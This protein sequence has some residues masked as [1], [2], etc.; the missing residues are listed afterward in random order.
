[1]STKN[2]RSGGKYTGAHTTVIPAA[3]TVCDIAHKLS[4][5]SKI[6]LGFI[7]AGLPSVGGQRRVKVIDDKGSLLL[8]IRDNA[9]HQEVRVFTSNLPVTKLAIARGIR[10]NGFH[11]SFGKAE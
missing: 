5:V 7:K 3:G 9:S 4:E 8:S 1:M 2:T 10:N 6:S 11:L